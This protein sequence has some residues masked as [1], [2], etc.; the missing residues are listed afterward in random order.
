MDVHAARR[1]ARRRPRLRRAHVPAGRRARR[2]SSFDVEIAARAC[3]R[4][5]SPTSSGCSR[6][7][8][9]CSR[10]RSSSPT[11]AASRCAIARAADGDAA[12]R[13]R[14]SRER[15]HVLAFAVTR[16]R[17]RH[18]GG[19]AAA[20]LRGVPAGRRHDEPQYG[21]TGLGLSISREIARLLGGEIRVAV[22]AGRGQ[23]V[24]ALP[25][26]DVRRSTPATRWRRSRRDSTSSSREGER[27]SP[28]ARAARRAGCVAEL[29]L[30]R[31]APAER[32]RRRPRR[33]SSRATASC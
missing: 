21:G 6:C 13:S 26:G 15:R 22:D 3:R 24:H 33:R 1:R 27:S 23:H 12:S 5:S 28:R 14:R 31:A 18:P 2:A 8:R 16:H 20:H 30:D 4:R 10:T 17:H 9:T 7:S 29:D 19:Q 32:G 25:A 11:R